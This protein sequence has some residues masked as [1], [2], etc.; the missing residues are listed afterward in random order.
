MS[1]FNASIRFE[2]TQ[3]LNAIKKFK[4]LSSRNIAD[5]INQEA[6]Y[7]SLNSYRFTRKADREWLKIKMFNP[8][9]VTRR[10]RIKS[11]EGKISYEKF[12]TID[13]YGQPTGYLYRMMYHEKPEMLAY[14]KN[15]S[16]PYEER[17][18]ELTKKAIKFGRA[19]LSHCGYTR[20]GWFWAKRGFGAG[21]ADFKFQI[22]DRYGDYKKAQRTEEI[23]FAFLEN[24]AI[25]A[26]IYALPALKLAF[27]LQ[28]KYVMDEVKRRLQNAANKFKPTKT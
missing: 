8:K 24:S 4:E 13:E 15:K 9:K 20:M 7:I 21:G 26:P 11:P 2:Y 3:W 5:I 6:K 28:A 25:L 27:S 18:R 10:R 19:V 12:E 22:Y 23:K 1:G 14:Y 16:I 17:R